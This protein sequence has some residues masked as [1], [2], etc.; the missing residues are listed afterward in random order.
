MGRH[1]PITN[2]GTAP[3][4]YGEG[5]P[6]IGVKTIALDTETTNKIYEIGGNII[7]VPDASSLDAKVSIRY[8]EET[9][10]PIPIQAGSF[11]AGPSFSRLFISWAA[12]AGETITILYT[13]DSP[14]RRFRIENATA[15]YTGVSVSGTVDVEETDNNDY[16]S[17]ADYSVPATTAAK[18]REISADQ[19]YI[20]VSNLASNTQTMRIGDSNVGAAR[21]TPL[22][23]GETLVLATS[24]AVWAYNPGAGAESLAITRIRKV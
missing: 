5:T 11:I 22:A 4:E 24:D 6:R 17:T 18:I 3:L 20:I 13:T 1:H 7:W 8:Q 12:Q 10:D 9:N 19:K 23:P 2:T 14:Q 16:R 21:G 15:D